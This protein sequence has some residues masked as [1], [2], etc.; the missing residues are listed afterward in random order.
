MV[1]RLL[2]NP[3]RFTLDFML[4]KLVWS[5]IVNVC[6]G[7]LLTINGQCDWLSTEALSWEIKWKLI[8]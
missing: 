4:A 8:E 1:S 7:M 2:N 3:N 5:L 6:L